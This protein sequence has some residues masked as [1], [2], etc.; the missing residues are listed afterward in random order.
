MNFLTPISSVRVLHIDS[1]KSRSDKVDRVRLIWVQASVSSLVLA[2]AVHLWRTGEFL[3][4]QFF[5]L[6]RVVGLSKCIDAQR[7]SSKSE[8]TWRRAYHR[9]LQGSQLLVSLSSVQSR[10]VPCC[11]GRFSNDTRCSRTLK[12]RWGRRSWTT[13]DR[14]GEE[15]SWCET[16]CKDRSRRSDR[17]EAHPLS[18]L[19]W[20]KKREEEALEHTSAGARIMII[21]QCPIRELVDC[22]RRDWDASMCTADE[23][24]WQLV[25]DSRRPS[26]DLSSLPTYLN[27]I[28]LSIFVAVAWQAF[29][30]FWKGRAS[31]WVSHRF[32]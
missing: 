13:T 27:A 19:E 2:F 7:P 31:K 10:V 32:E 24:G 17:T 6:E 5:D 3:Q 26:A 23:E 12:E 22:C 18:R 28:G 9:R 11:N 15:W 14:H 16:P 30:T 8:E 4:V 29:T 20:L 25:I 1:S 21:P